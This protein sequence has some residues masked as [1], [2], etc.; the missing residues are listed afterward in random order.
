MIGGI[1]FNIIFAVVCYGSISI[2]F[3]FQFGR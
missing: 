1:V 2:A 3:R